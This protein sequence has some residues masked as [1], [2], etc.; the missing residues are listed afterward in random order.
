MSWVDGK[1]SLRRT[2]RVQ[3]MTLV[4]IEQ[5]TL[6]GLVHLPMCRWKQVYFPPTLTGFRTLGYRGRETASGIAAADSPYRPAGMGTRYPEAQHAN[7]PT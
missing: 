4:S 2:P 1:M 7:I 6:S 5:S 3:P